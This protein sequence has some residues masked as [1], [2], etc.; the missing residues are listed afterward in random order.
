MPLPNPLNLR[1]S[2]TILI[3][4]DLAELTL[5]NNIQPFLGG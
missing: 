3:E 1:S 4:T 2:I 5:V